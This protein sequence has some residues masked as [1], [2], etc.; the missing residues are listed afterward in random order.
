MWQLGVHI[1]LQA[2]AAQG[3]LFVLNYGYVLYMDWD[4]YIDPLSAPPLDMLILQWPH[5]ALYVQAAQRFNA[6]EHHVLPHLV[7]VQTCAI[8]CREDITAGLPSCVCWLHPLTTTFPPRVDALEGELLKVATHLNHAIA[9]KRL[10]LSSFD[11]CSCRC[12]RLAVAALQ[13]D[14]QVACRLVATGAIW[15]I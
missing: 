13:T 11:W 12:R 5:R 9:H 10:S 2:P 15:A 7:N 6:G 1:C 14:T 3:A 8:G 4:S